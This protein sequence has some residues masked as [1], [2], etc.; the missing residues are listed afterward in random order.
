[1]SDSPLSYKQCPRCDSTEITCHRCDNVGR[2]KACGVAFCTCPDSFF[3]LNGIHPHEKVEANHRRFNAYEQTLYKHLKV[4][5]WVR[6]KWERRNGK[7]HY[8]T[9]RI[10]GFVTRTRTDAPPQNL[11]P[12]RTYTLA[13]VAWRYQGTRTEPLHLLQ[14][15]GTPLH[16]VK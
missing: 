10:V 13:V 4:G 6:V 14:P 3:T 1:M 15:M 8:R 16:V 12:T 5:M 11:P 2:C 7:G 9:G